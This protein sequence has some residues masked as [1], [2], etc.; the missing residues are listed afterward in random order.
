MTEETRDPSVK[1]DPE[2]RGQ[3]RI[4]RSG[5][6]QE[7]RSNTGP[8][9]RRTGIPEGSESTGSGSD[10][11]A[12]I[13]SRPSDHVVERLKIAKLVAE[14]GDDYLV[15]DTRTQAP[16]QLDRGQVDLQYDA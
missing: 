16:D 10:A 4:R 13:G 9:L 3:W 2:S 14:T 8:V 6:A 12:A 7:D 15:R 5:R 1:I 11:T